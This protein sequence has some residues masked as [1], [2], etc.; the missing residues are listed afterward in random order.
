MGEQGTESIHAHKMRLEGIHQGIPDNVDLLK[1]IFK[2]HMLE[3]DPSLI[4]LRPS[5]KRR[6]CS[7]DNL[8]DNIDSGSVDYPY[9]L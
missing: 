1:Y 6:K 7:P 4:S 3:S 8:D 2:E 9:I 5:P